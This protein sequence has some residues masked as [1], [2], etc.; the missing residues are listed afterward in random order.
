V[1]FVPSP[2]ISGWKFEDSETVEL[3]LLGARCGV[4]PAFTWERG[5][6]GKILDCPL[7]ASERPAVEE[8]LAPAPVPAPGEARSRHRLAR[9][10]ARARADHG[11]APRLGAGERRA[12]LPAGGAE[13]ARRRVGASASLPGFEHGRKLAAPAPQLPRVFPPGDH[14]RGSEPALVR[15]R[16]ARRAGEPRP[17]VPPPR[18]G[19]RRVGSAPGTLGCFRGLIAR[20]APSPR[21]RYE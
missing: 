11:T 19:V 13:V 21:D 8:F 6:G 18:R 1:L 4:F 3:A 15:S 10:A 9:G 14:E 20:A 12:A 5:K 16:S 7:A 17:R 2:C